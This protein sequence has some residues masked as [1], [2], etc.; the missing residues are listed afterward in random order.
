MDS[1]VYVISDLHL[2]PGRDAASGQWNA[3]EDFQADEALCAFLD[4]ISDASRAP[5]ELLIA[6]DF[7][8]YPQILPDMGLQSPSNDLGTTEAESVERTRV[9]LGQL[10]EI[11]SGH[12]TVFQR[13]RQLMADGHAI[14]ILVGNHDIDLLWPGVWELLFE[15][16]Y[17]P[18]APGQLR[19]ETF[20]RTYG[21][22]PRGRVYIEHGHERDIQNCFGDQMTQPFAYDQHGTQRLKRC[23]GTLFV[24]KVYNKLEA[25]RW[26][27]DNVK[28]IARVIKLGLTND[29]RF[30][31]GAL[32]LITKF[33]LTSGASLHVISG[34]VLS[35]EDEPASVPPEQR[36]AETVVS[37]VADPQLRGELEQRLSEPAFRQEFEREVQ[38]QYEENDWQ[39]IAQG[40]GQQP[41][42]DEAANEPPAAAVLGAEAEDA[43]RS[44]ARAILAA[45]GAISTVIMG[46]THAAIDGLIA[47]IYLDGGRTGY[48]YNSG[49]WTWHLRERPERYTWQQIADVA[50]YTSSFTYLRLE[51]D[52]R[53]V[54]QVTLRNWSA[55][56]NG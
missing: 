35:A 5:F 17:P 50:N 22:G 7:I 34:G 48:Y 11:A 37:S 29:F 46:H 32:A 10:P 41:S 12:P 42:L 40:G 13:L 56:W 15:A 33:F 43:Y 45:D 9:V 24:D 21:S 39:A 1:I 26:F 14:T 52:A 44:A 3:L 28:P 31:A 20:S 19:R 25:D 6:G 38:Q 51:P 53:G 49:T 4:H 55:E 54:Y 23:W 36:T 18:G 16:I 47:P 30:T 8:D 27:I 2:G